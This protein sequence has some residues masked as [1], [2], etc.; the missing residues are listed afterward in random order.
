MAALSNGA[1][2]GR[3]FTVEKVASTGFSF[4]L[5]RD[6]T[7]P[8]TLL[9]STLSMIDFKGALSKFTSPENTPPLNFSV[10]K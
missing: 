5:M 9:C 4:V 6:W 10:D 3:N 7:I 1:F 2:R 8:H